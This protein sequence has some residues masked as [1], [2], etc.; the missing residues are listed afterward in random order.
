MAEG[1]SVEVIHAL[2]GQIERVELKLPPGST[3]QQALDASGLL[4]KHHLDAATGRFGIYG[5]L[6]GPD[7]VLRDRDR[8]EIYRPLVADPQ[9][10]RRARA[11]KRKAMKK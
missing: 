1:I 2:P 5:R 9:E 6:A 11:A 4:G 10:V 7:T 8:I 3:L